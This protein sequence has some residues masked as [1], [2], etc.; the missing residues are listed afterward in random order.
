[1]SLSLLIPAVALSAG[2]FMSMQDP[3]AELPTTP[4]DGE[5]VAVMETDL[6]RIVLMFYPQKAPLHVE[7]FKTLAK[8]G[9]YD[10]TRFHRTIPNFMV[11]G[12]DPNSRDLDKAQW[13]G[14]GGH[15]MDG[16]EVNVKAEFNDVK[17]LPG[18][19]SMARSSDPDSASSQFFI[20]HKT[21]PHLDGQYSAFGR[22]VEGMDVV[23]KIATRPSGRN[24]SVDPM[25][26][27]VLKSVKIEKW[28]LKKGG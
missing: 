5:E 22:V 26:A 20:M 24:G 1:M 16:K 12:G 7:N 17:H 14:T 9:F 19:L 8:K 28:P 10:G 15:E 18:V 4:K 2:M 25:K 23:D 27:V 6:G 21:S 11:Q 13:W 3:Q